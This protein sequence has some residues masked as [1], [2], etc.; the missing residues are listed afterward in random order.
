MIL[1]W[2]GLGSRPC[3]ILRSRNKIKNMLGLGDEL[4]NEVGELIPLRL[5]CFV[6]MYKYGVCVC[7]LHVYCICLLKCVCVACILYVY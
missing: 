4:M 2:K 1:T 7:V 5:F 3:C 6:H